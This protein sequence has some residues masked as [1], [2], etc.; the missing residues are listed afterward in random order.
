MNQEDVIRMARE[1][2]FSVTHIGDAIGT[3]CDMLE[4]FAALVAA[5]VLPK[6]SLAEMFEWGKDE[7]KREER[8]ECAKACEKADR[9]R[10]DYFAAVIRAR[11][12]K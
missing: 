9:Y 3:P 7:G 6:E 2:G 8:E 12:R 11:G 5:A 1:A 10:G 4:R